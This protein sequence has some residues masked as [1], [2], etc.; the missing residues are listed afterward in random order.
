MKCKLPGPG[1]ELGLLVPFPSTITIMISVPPTKYNTKYNL[2][3]TQC[4]T[5]SVS[6]KDWTHYSVDL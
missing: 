5:C 1:F 6:S 3:L 4:Y 2:D